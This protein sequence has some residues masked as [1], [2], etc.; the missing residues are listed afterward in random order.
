[1]EALQK[2]MKLNL[3]TKLFEEE[4][5]TYCGDSV[6][7]SNIGQD[8]QVT[9]P[10]SLL[11]QFAISDGGFTGGAA[12]VFEED[13]STTME[14]ER[15]WSGYAANYPIPDPVVDAPISGS[16]PEKQKKPE[17]IPT[18]E[19]GFVS[20]FDNK[21][22]TNSYDSQNCSTC[23]HVLNRVCG[24]DDPHCG[25]PV[26]TD[27]AN[28]AVREQQKSGEEMLCT[29]V[30]FTRADS[31]FQCVAPSKEKNS[32]G[33]PET[34]YLCGRPRSFDVSGYSCNIASNGYAVTPN[35]P[36]PEPSN[37]GCTFTALQNGTLDIDQFLILNKGV[38]S[39]GDQKVCGAY[40][41]RI[42]AEASCGLRD[43]LKESGTC[44]YE[45]DRQDAA[46][47]REDCI[48]ETG[49]CYYNDIE[50]T[51]TGTKQEECE[52]DFGVCQVTFED[53]SAED[54]E[55]MTTE[56][57]C[58][59]D[60]E[61]VQTRWTRNTSWTRD[62]ENT[63]MTDN[64]CDLPEGQCE[65][66]INTEGESRCAWRKTLTAIC[67][68]EDF[69][70]SG[71]GVKKGET[72][73][74]FSNGVSQERGFKIGIVADDIVKDVQAGNEDGFLDLVIVGQEDAEKPESF[75]SGGYG[76]GGMDDDVWDTKD[77]EM[78]CEDDQACGEPK[79]CSCGYIGRG[80][81]VNVQFLCTVGDVCYN[82]VEDWCA[83]EEEICITPY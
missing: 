13:I 70:A 57:T 39:L 2:E 41:K 53:D 67:N 4:F 12:I 76:S 10:T 27:W 31:K 83:D 30:Q 58:A 26:V 21:D 54:F 79:D 1:M 5:Y 28:L 55:E 32:F 8:K 74:Y 71:L 72:F 20:C 60:R 17:D 35:F 23:S 33:Q 73:T 69:L 78:V 6:A 68:K 11:G 19:G 22:S 7:K 81:D 37:G 16:V 15:C 14:E 56:K 47:T 38:A 59:T 45:D 18:P 64:E 63:W 48:V 34:Y 62:E 25:L 65:D 82:Q 77:S 24:E 80:T 44:I 42:S 46:T 9:F 75:G 3:Y 50:K 51:R 66:Y 43:G 36:D 52:L 49:T 40:V 29:G 61:G